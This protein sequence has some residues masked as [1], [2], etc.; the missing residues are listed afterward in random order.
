M[1][2]LTRNQLIR[3]AYA[4]GLIAFEAVG[5]LRNMDR[6]EA[7]LRRRGLL[8]YDE[9]SHIHR[10]TVEG[11]A[12]LVLAR[13]VSVDALPDEIR[14]EVALDALRSTETPAAAE[15]DRQ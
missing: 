4:A 1:R 2:K 15:S 5:N 12:A 7:A 11:W 8:A 13:R 9:T 14:A 6:T 3:L 10:I